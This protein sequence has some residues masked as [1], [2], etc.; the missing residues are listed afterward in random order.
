M[1]AS[2]TNSDL[3]DEFDSSELI[4]DVKVYIRSNPWRLVWRQVKVDNV[5]W[6]LVHENQTR[7][8]GQK[9]ADWD[10]KLDPDKRHWDRRVTIKLPKALAQAGAYLLTAE[11]QNGN[12]A[13]VIIWV[14]DTT[15]IKKPLNKQVLYY[16]ADAVNG[17]PLAGTTVDF[18]GYRTQQIKGKNRYRIRHKGFSRQTDKDGQVILSPTEMGN[19]LNWLATVGVGGR[20]AFL[21]FSSIWY[22]NYH[23]REYNQTKTLIMTDRPVYRPKQSVRFKIWVRQAQYDKAKKKKKEA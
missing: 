17:K 10:L 11:M 9:T 19:N 16:V 6:R 8:V 7:Y 14:S 21:G 23:D 12:T 1:E 5:G 20:M 4:E 3:E 18:F 13:R 2:E 22:P 15:I